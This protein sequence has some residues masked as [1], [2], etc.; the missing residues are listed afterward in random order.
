[1]KTLILIEIIVKLQNYKVKNFFWFSTTDFLI[2]N[3]T[4][5]LLFHI[6]KLKIHIIKFIKKKASKLQ[7]HKTHPHRC[8]ESVVNVEPL[9]ARIHCELFAFAYGVL[10]FYCRQIPWTRRVCPGFAG[11]PEPSP[12]N[13]PKYFKMKIYVR[14]GV[15]IS[16]PPD[17]SRHVSPCVCA[18]YLDFGFSGV[19]RGW[20]VAFDGFSKVFVNRFDRCCVFGAD[21]AG[22]N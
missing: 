22:G 10:S 9:G 14:V 19:G 13:G 17:S 21:D 4:I 8:A 15:Q 11:R 3:N 12:R 1:M 2:K 20:C 18:L 5:K 6:Q 7:K 16:R